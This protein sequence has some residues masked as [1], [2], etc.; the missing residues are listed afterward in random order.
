MQA[1]EIEMK[2][3]TIWFNIFHEEKEKMFNIVK[4]IK[5]NKRKKSFSNPLKWKKKFVF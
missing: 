2:T 3:A 4:K 5:T 1:D